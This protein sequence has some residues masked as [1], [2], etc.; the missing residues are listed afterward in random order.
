[1]LFIEWLP[2][3]NGLVEIEPVRSIG[4][5]L[6]GKSGWVVFDFHFTGEVNFHFYW[7]YVQSVLVNSSL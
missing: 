4:W 5:Y 1:M 3:G 7:N 6:S 2:D